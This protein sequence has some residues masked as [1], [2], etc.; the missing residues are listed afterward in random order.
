MFN[1][2]GWGE[3]AVLLVLALLVFGPERLPRMAAQAGRMVRQFKQMANGVTD[4]LKRE[5]GAEDLDF[6]ELRAM[7]PRRMVDPRRLINDAVNP[8]E[9]PLRTATATAAL[10]PGEAAPFDPDAT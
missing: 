10:A 2:L 8:R 1:N 7:D 3:S 9:T 6:A 5:I 4:D